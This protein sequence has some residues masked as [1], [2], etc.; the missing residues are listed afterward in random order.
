VGLIPAEKKE[1]ISTYSRGKALWSLVRESNKRG[2]LRPRVV[3]Q[4]IIDKVRHR[5][6][7]EK[8]QDAAAARAMKEMTG[9]RVK[10]AKFGDLSLMRPPTPRPALP[11]DRAARSWEWWEEPITLDQTPPKSLFFFGRDS[12]VRRAC[13]A[14]YKSN[15]ARAFFILMLITN[16]VFVSLVP[17]NING[18]T[19]NGRG[20]AAQ[21]TEPTSALE[22]TL[23]WAGTFDLVCMTVLCLE[24]L[25]GSAACG[26]ASSKHMSWLSASAVNPV[27]LIVLIFAIVEYGLLAF[28][29]KP[30]MMR[31]LRLL[32]LFRLFDTV[33]V[34]W[35]I[36]AMVITLQKGAGQF[37]SVWFVFLS[38][39]VSF[40]IFGMELY[41]ESFSRSCRVQG[42]EVF[43]GGYPYRTA[44]SFYSETDNV[45]FDDSAQALAISRTMMLSADR[46]LVAR[47]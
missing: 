4:Q 46:K 33:P 31:S 3:L 37:V 28:G 39:V 7:Q 29:Y 40:G 13:W 12:A 41:P 36:N 25:I 35:H 20:A 42:S 15:T 2:E 32:R 6:E 30:L 16:N 45:I 44:C 11:S 24:I 1:K 8:T 23:V 18:S 27:D 38:F 22:D 43:M 34:L 14:V 10:A 5:A 47:P 9:L 21:P 17:D 26:L 19:L